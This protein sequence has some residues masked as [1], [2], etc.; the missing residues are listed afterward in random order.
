LGGWLAYACNGVWFLST[1]I[2]VN[3]MNR[4]ILQKALD[5]LDIA[6]SLLERSQHYDQIL[7]AYTSL[8][9]E[10]AKPEQEPYC[11]VQSKLNQGLFYKEKPRR[12][13]TISLYTSP[14]RK[15]WFGLTN[16]ELQN[17]LDCG[18][19]FWTNAEKIEQLLKDKNI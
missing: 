1:F 11:W 3:N 5:A 17:I 8:R 19:G 16:N 4:E 12:I 9:D 13:H 7:N 14:P 2:G 6:Q 18:R 15:E 10:L